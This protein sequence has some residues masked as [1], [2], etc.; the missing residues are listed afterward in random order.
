MNLTALWQLAL[1]AV[2]INNIVLTRFLGL[3]PCF[4][5]STSISGSAKMGAAVTM[6]LFVSTLLYWPIDVFVLRPN[7]VAYLQTITV[8]LVIAA[9]VQILEIATLKL[10]PVFH[11]SMGIYLP[12]MTTNC[13]IIGVTLLGTGKNPIT[14]DQFTYI[15]SIVHSIGCGAGFTVA[16]V[17]LCGIQEKLQLSDV[18]RPLRGLPIT[19]MAVGLMAMAF[20]GFSG[21]NPTR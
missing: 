11:Q 12:L 5:L 6:V 19:L 15:E 7:G 17:L 20:F 4:G 13:A 14:G 10:S 8:I 21:M 2:L 9:V 16:I 18:P 1:A 3:C